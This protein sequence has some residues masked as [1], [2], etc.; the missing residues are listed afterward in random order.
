[1]RMDV[2]R[3]PRGVTRWGFV[4]SV[5]LAA[6]GLGLGLLA[7]AAIS[8]RAEAQEA[9]WWEFIPGFG[10]SGT[11]ASARRT[12]YQGREGQAEQLGDLRTDPTPLRSDAMVTALEDAIARY[13]EIAASGGWAPIPGSRMMRPGDDDER[14][15]LV[16]RRLIMTGDLRRQ[17][18]YQSYAFDGELEAAVRRF[19]DRHG[20]R[21]SGR[22]DRPTLQAMN[23]PVQVRL[24]QL[25]LN[26]HR[27][28]ELIG[29]RIEDRYILVNVPAF[30]LEAV[31]RYNVAERHRV[32]AGKPERQ[33][34]TVKAQVRAL[35]FFPYWRVPDSV[36][37][38]DLI[39][40]LQKE[41]DYLAKEQIRVLTGSFNGPEIDPANIDWRQADATR[42]KFRQDPGPQNAL[43]LVRLDMPNEHGVYMHDTPMKKLFDQRGRAFSAGC[44]RVQNVFDLAAWIARDEPGGI[45][46]QRIEDILAAGNAVDIQLTRPVPVY[47][48]YVTAWAEPD[49]RVEFRPDIYGRDGLKELSS[50]RERDPDAPPPPS[51]SLAP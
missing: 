45:D 51:Q 21:S 32:I 14:I 37:T 48:T 11:P 50:D 7:S 27:I 4:I 6:L 13:Q 19:Q 40:R 1:M 31:E 9:N 28:R 44:V 49:G 42:I 20:L 33:T 8:T 22:I 5:V 46:R 2:K 41:P 18:S 47:F 16:R 39:P 38:L 26:Q 34:P 25:R 35:N 23:V 3:Q 29:Q 12:D 10:S 24:A 17:Q 15:P 43:G 30:Q 36:A